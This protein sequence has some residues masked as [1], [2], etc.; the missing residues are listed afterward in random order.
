M[1]FPRIYNLDGVT[2]GA[3]EIIGIPFVFSDASPK[4]VFQLP[5]GCYLVTTQIKIVV[6]FD[7]AA[8]TLLIGDNLIPD[9]YMKAE[10]ND[11]TEIAEYETNPYEKITAIKNIYLAISPAASVQGSGLVV[12][13]YAVN[14]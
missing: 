14:S 13:E 10:E 11:P 7:D 8:A 1:P 9:K 4:M 6:P 5:A 12:I 2:T 3:S